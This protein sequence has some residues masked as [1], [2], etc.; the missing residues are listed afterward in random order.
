MV[1]LN[2]LARR[3]DSFSPHY[4]DNLIYRSMEKK[5][6]QI[7]NVAEVA[8]MF[9]VTS[10][11]VNRWYHIYGLP[12]YRFAEHKRTSIFFR[13]EEVERWMNDHR[14]VSFGETNNSNK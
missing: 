6:K 12:H 5:E 4:F 9:G 3:F 13:R 1:F 7:L 11:T 10:A 2:T 14:V 8:Q